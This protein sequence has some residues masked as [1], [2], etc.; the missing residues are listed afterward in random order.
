MKRPF[1]DAAGLPEAQ[2]GRV[3]REEVFVITS[4]VFDF[5]GVIAE[6]GFKEGLAAIGTGNG[7]DP[8]RFFAVA[9]ELI[10]ETGYVTGHAPE[11]AYWD[12]VRRATGVQGAD[13]D[14]REEI[15]SRFV[16]RPDM[17]DAV[18][19]FWTQG[20]QV[21]ILS[22]QTDWLDEIEVATGFSRRFD[23]VLNS[24]HLGKSKREPSLFHDVAAMLHKKPEEIMFID[25]NENNVRRAAA[26]GW[27]AMHFRNVESFRRELTR[28][29]LPPD[30]GE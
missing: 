2:R 21:S 17:L 22:D 19:R 4:I 14:L 20:F 16:L 10:Y 25:D 26:Q 12:A 1:A 6:E 11:A 8:E 28:V 29:L 7:L 5:G 23:R 27:N 13:V 30:M 9:R 24:Y 3:I 15:I 18:D